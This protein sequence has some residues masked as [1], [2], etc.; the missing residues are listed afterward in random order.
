MGGARV[1]S[2]GL[3]GDNFTLFLK[4]DGTVWGSGAN[5]GGGG[6][7]ITAPRTVTPNPDGTVTLGPETP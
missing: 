6:V 2:A 7:T 1:A 3:N 5:F 4:G